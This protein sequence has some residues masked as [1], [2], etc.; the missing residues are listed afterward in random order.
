MKRHPAKTIWVVLLCL[1]VLVYLLL[2]GQVNIRQFEGKLTAQSQK[3]LLHLAQAKQRHCVDLFGLMQRQLCY[4]ASRIADYDV[5]EGLPQLAEQVWDQAVLSLDCTDAQ[6]AVVSRLYGDAANEVRSYLSWS[7]FFRRSRSGAEAVSMMMDDSTWPPCI[8]MFYPICE[9]DDFGEML[10]LRISVN[11]L[12]QRLEHDAA[13]EGIRTCLVSSEGKILAGYPEQNGRLPVLSI[14]SD[15][16][17]ARSLLE[18]IEQH[19]SGIGVFD[20]QSRDGVEPKNYLAGYWPL[21]VFCSSWSIAAIQDAGAIKTAVAEHAR[22]IQLGM[23]C[24]FLT[25]ILILGLYYHSSHQRIVYEQQKALGQATEE[26]HH[27]SEQSRQTRQDMERQ[28]ILYRGLLNAIPMGL[29]WKNSEG[30]LI[31]YNPEYAHLMGLKRMEEGGLSSAQIEMF[32]QKQDGMPLDMEVMNKDIELLFLP[33]SYFHNGVMNNYLVSKI[34]VKDEQGQICGLLG[35]VLNRDLLSSYRDRTFCGGLKTECINV[36]LPIP[37]LVVD[38]LGRSLGCNPAFLQRFEIN[39]PPLYEQPLRDILPKE[40]ADAIDTFIGQVV[41]SQSD[42][43]GSFYMRQGQECFRATARPVFSDGSL[44][45]VLITL[46]D[47]DVL[48]QTE[49]YL[50]HLVFSYRRAVKE[51]SG[52]FDD[53][54]EKT[55]QL[56]HNPSQVSAKSLNEYQCRII[57]CLE[58]AAHCDA[59][60]SETTD[61]METENSVVNVGQLVEAVRRHHSQQ[62]RLSAVLLDISVGAKCPSLFKGDWHKLYQVLTILAEQAAE[63]AIDGRITLHID[64]AETQGQN[65]RVAFAVE[66]SGVLSLGEELE[67]IINPD[68]SLLEWYPDCMYRDQAINLR[69]AA[70]LLARLGER[71]RVERFSGQTRYSFELSAVADSGS[72]KAMSF[73]TDQEPLNHEFHRETSDMQD[74]NKTNKR[75][76]DPQTIRILVVDDVEENRT[77]LEVILS[78]LGYAAVQCSGGKQAIAMCRQEA[79]DVVLMDIQMPEVDGLE[80]IRQIRADSLNTGV[81]IIAMTASSQK[82]DELAALESGCDDYLNKPINRK[83]LEQK[84]WRNLA[85]MRQIREAEQGLDITSFLEGDSDYHKTIETFVGNLPNRI[86]EMRQAMDKH[87]LK[88]LAFKVHALKGL[89]GFAGFAV[90]TEKAA[91]LEESIHEQDMNKIQEQIDEMVQLCMRT[92]IKNDTR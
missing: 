56:L 33:H 6:G 18:N 41:R 37:T 47:V 25:V 50:E 15:D 34:A 77:L 17:C 83:L 76:R 22:N 35:S 63:F 40:S 32:D 20:G 7:A 84:I 88:D 11:K 14:R 42:E 16:V 86:E 27:L 44:K 74:E 36:L 53:L 29:Y 61:F 39:N 12:L 85:K 13:A 26:L 58:K 23:V 67:H 46:T 43:A 51:L 52:Q 68:V 91:R 78:K 10:I 92:K 71:L 31:G 65:A 80:A 9:S 55:R 2:L 81:P 79:Y 21:D 54:G 5:P 8:V 38:Y 4:A 3:N 1:G 82:D 24:L 75:P 30:R 19:R 90:Y 28:I 89:G 57:A 72:A 66:H 59:L 60:S 45:C 48:K 73:N 64:I 70:R 62:E 49:E 69:V 87:D